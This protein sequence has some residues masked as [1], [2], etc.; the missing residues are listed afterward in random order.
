M[1]KQPIQTAAAPQ[2]GG[3]YSQGITAGPLVFLAG[4][5]PFN[6]DTGAKVEGSFLDQ[7]RQAF[8][9]LAAVAKATGGSLSDAVR[10]G[11]YLRDM[12]DFAAMN[13]IYSEY[14]EDP[15]PA[16]TTIQSDLPG[17]SIE[18]DAILHLG[19]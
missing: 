9:N 11:V 10:V 3:P 1:A 6:P 17:F 18:I 19:E 12:T 7:A 14:F 2:P 15:L 8:E 13:E 4:Q 5:G 16:R